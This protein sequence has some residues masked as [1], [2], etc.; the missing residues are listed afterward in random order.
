MLET[1]GGGARQNLQRFSS[2]SVEVRE[3]AVGVG[4]GGVRGGLALDGSSGVDTES[5]SS[6]SI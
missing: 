4:G 1:G 2:R 5:A 6:Q 3:E